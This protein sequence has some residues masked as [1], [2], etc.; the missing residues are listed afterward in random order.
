MKCSGQILFDS[1]FLD[2]GLSEMGGETRVSIA[3][4]LGGKAEPSV[5]VIEV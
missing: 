1:E 3:D 2:D 5:Y 4:D